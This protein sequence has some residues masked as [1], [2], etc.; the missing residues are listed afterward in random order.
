MRCKSDAHSMKRSRSSTQT[1]SDAGFSLM[2]VL[3]ALLIL[4]LVVSLTAPRV[5]GY[6]GK[7]KG[8]TAGVQIENLKSALDLFLLDTGRY[9]TEQEGLSVLGI[10]GATIPG[11]AG[12]YLDGTEAPLDPWGNAYIYERSQTGFGVV[13][14]SL[15]RDQEEGGQGEDA[16]IG[17]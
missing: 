1:S 14:Y 10:S 4:S 9:P 11:W 7:A 13:V 17:R 15:G 6:L 12:P 8:Q 16:D 2:E 5:L 3:I